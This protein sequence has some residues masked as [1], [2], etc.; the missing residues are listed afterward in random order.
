MAQSVVHLTHEPEIL[1]FDTPVWH[2]LLFL[3]PLIQEGHLSVTGKSMCRKYWL[4]VRRY[5]PA[6]EKCG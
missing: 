1:G 6:Q 4:T 2:L 3:L 5:K